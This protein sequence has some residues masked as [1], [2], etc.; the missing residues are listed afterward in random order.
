M[1]SFLSPI[2]LRD[3]C[4]DGQR[5]PRSSVL[6]NGVGCLTDSRVSTS[7][8]ASQLLLWQHDSEN[9]GS[10]AGGPPV[11]CLVG[12][13]RS[14]WDETRQSPSPAVNLVFRFSGLRTF[15]ALHLYALDVP[16]RNVSFCI[17]HFKCV[18]I[19]LYLS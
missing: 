13:N 5:D 16:S 2:N 4:Y 14:Q 1:N 17:T 19:S 3:K 6:H 10:T 12:W 7:V 11:D 15:E 8:K 18:H 9:T